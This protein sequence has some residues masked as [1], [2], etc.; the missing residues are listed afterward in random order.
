[1]GMN[2][3]E[4]LGLRNLEN[5]SLGYLVVFKV[6]ESWIFRVSLRFIKNS[7]LLKTVYRWSQ[8]VDHATKL[9]FLDFVDNI[10]VESFRA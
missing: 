3:E 8:V 5:N 6:D 9:T 2:V 4:E 7:N 1:M 10:I